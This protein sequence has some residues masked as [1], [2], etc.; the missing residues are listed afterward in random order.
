MSYSLALVL[1][2]LGSPSHTPA[3]P[4][5]SIRS[6]AGIRAAALRHSPDVRKCYETEGLARNPALSGSVEV[7]LTILPSGAV[8]EVH[9][10][11][12]RLEGIGKVEVG[13]CV[14][15]AARRWTFGRGPY[16]TETIILPF[17]LSRDV[18]RGQS[19][20]RTS[21]AQD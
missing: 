18:P 14:A 3:I 2:L 13:K 11:T 9:I 1:S 8:S 17:Q 4:N 7:E 10:N 21:I 19:A 15:T 16:V 12:D 20:V 5:D 6:D